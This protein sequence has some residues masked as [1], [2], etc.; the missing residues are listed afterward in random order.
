MRHSE[1][2]DPQL[3]QLA[4]GL[5]DLG[6]GRSFSGTEALTAALGAGIENHLAAI[7][8]ALE[9]SEDAGLICEVQKRPPRWQ[10]V[11]TNA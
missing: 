10:V 7:D 4:K 3:S 11:S 8:P 6:S 2:T 1:L 5:T 9:D